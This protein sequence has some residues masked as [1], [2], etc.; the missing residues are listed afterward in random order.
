MG[1]KSDA[2]A[3]LFLFFVVGVRSVHPRK[4]TAI[5]SWEEKVICLPYDAMELR[6]CQIIMIMISNII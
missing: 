4:R 2:L 6:W 1:K 5:K 3:K